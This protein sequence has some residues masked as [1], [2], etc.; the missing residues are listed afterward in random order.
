MPEI[1]IEDLLRKSFFTSPAFAPRIDIPDVDF[2]PVPMPTKEQADRQL[3]HLAETKVLLAALTQTIQNTEAD[4]KQ[5]DLDRAEQWVFNRRMTIVAVALSFA[6]VV[7]PF[8]IFFLEHG[9]WWKPTDR[10]SGR[11]TR[12]PRQPRPAGCCG[13]G[14]AYVR[15]PFHAVAPLP[16]IISPVSDSTAGSPCASPASISAH[17]AAVLSRS[18]PVC[19]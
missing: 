7:A 13:P 19:H 14:D 1:P 12:M 16:S 8:F 6:A 15:L 3:A 5:A 4:R 2:T 10:D 18:C 9:W 17:K 11:K